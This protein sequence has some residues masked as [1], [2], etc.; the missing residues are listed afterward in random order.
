MTRMTAEQYRATIGKPANKYHAVKTTVDGI[1]FDSKAEARRYG[2]LKLMHRAGEIRG[3]GIQP[4]FVLSGGIRYRP[5][6]I[7]CGK[8][9]TVW[10]EDVKGVETQAFKLKR[11]L[12]EKEYPWLP[13]RVVKG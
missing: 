11:K 8:D 3:F 2:E 7:V 5:D 10:A 12:W 1:T 13:L 9:G 4:S 6:F